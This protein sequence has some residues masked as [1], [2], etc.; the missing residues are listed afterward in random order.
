MLFLMLELT[1]IQGVVETVLL[2]QFIV[3]ALF[4]D[5][6][7]PHNKDHVRLLDGGKAVGDDEGGTAL[8]HFYESALNAH[9]GSGIDG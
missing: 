9:L 4:D 8:H 3:R 2:Q 6:S 5:V 1:V 7:V